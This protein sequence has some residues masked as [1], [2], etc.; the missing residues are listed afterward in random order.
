MATFNTTEYAIEV[1]T[2]FDNA[3]TSKKEIFEKAVAYFGVEALT[4]KTGLSLRAMQAS[5]KPETKKK[6]ADAV[7]LSLAMAEELSAMIAEINKDR[8]NVW[9]DFQRA[10]FKPE[11]PEPKPKTAEEIAIAEQKAT[12]SELLKTS[13]ALSEQVALIKAEKTVLESQGKELPPE[14]MAE[15]EK[16]ETLKKGVKGK[17]DSLKERIDFMMLQKDLPAQIKKVTDFRKSLAKFLKADESVIG[18][19]SLN[20]ILNKL[21]SAA[22]GDNHIEYGNVYTVDE[23]GNKVD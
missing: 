9:Q 22:Y 13:K 3:A 17:T 20:G 19:M 2:A 23:D 10:Y 15:L 21:N 11:K 12:R 7:G 16:I 18:A 5:A 6:A 14:R 4:P 8:V 1:R